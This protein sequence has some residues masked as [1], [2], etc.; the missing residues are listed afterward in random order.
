MQKLLKNTKN[1][2]ILNWTKWLAEK[3]GMVDYVP[4]DQIEPIIEIKK[5]VIMAVPVELE[6]TPIIIA[7][8]E[9]VNEPRTIKK[10]GKRPTS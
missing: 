9:S 10:G 6:D 7:P 1:G 4:E 8:K 5:P 3:D 2:A